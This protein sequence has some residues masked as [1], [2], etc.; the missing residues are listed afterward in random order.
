MKQLIRAALIAAVTVG[1][2]G[3]SP[4]TQA[5]EKPA[6]AEHKKAPAAP[7]ATGEI[8]A[9][10]ATAGTLT[11]K[12]GK[13]GDKTFTVTVD[14]KIVGFGDTAKL[15]DLKAGEKVHVAYTEDAGKMTATKIAKVEPKAPKAPKAEKK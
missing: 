11:I 1:V 7:S 12:G 4:V 14:T 2:I 3:F 6:K 9:V 8:T 13:A 10:D 5:A 15:A